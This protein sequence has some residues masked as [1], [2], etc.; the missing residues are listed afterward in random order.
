MPEKSIPELHAKTIALTLAPEWVF[1]ALFSLALVGGGF[2]AKTA[3]ASLDK[4]SQ[5]LA[6]M[7]TS[8]VIETKAP[9]S[10]NAM[11]VVTVPGKIMVHSGGSVMDTSGKALYSYKDDRGAG[12]VPPIE[13][14]LLRLTRAIEMAST[15]PVLETSS[16]R[17]PTPEKADGR[18]KDKR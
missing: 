10:V 9:L 6:V 2:Y 11:T 12:P 18:K 5:A 13:F 7:S 15:P 14:S 4:I 8:V 3:T 1:L 17:T 16:S